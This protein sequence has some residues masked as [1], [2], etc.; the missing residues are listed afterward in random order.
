LGKV[1]A[2]AAESTRNFAGSEEDIRLPNKREEK[3]GN[4]T[5]MERTLRFGVD[6]AAELA[7]S[8]ENNPL[9]HRRSKGPP[10]GN[11]P[12]DTRLEENFLE[13][14]HPGESSSVDTHPVKGSPEDTPPGDSWL[15]GSLRPVGG[16]LAPSAGYNRPSEKSGEDNLLGLLELGHIV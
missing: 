6:F 15:A 3:K 9:G 16:T 7:G 2:E 5:A 12:V 1:E 10:V 14:S 13:D 11:L 4:K 8:A